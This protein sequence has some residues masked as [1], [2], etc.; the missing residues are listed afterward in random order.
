MLNEEEWE[1]LSPFL[2]DT[3]EKIKA[4]RA[5]HGC[6]IPT[7]RANCSPEAVAKFEE[8]TGFKNMGY[9]VMFYLRRS[10]YGPKCKSCGKLF[11]T[12]KATLCVACGQTLMQNS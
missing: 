3:I 6:D 9:D 8:L 1:Q 5:K 2:S 4:Y 12:P 11:R 7:A 10:D